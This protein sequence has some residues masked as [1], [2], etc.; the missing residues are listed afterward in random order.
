MFSLTKV[1]TVLGGA[2]ALGLHGENASNA[3]TTDAWPAFSWPRDLRSST[4][5][6]KKII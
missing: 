2:F 4:T 3:A 1:M 6:S 5:D